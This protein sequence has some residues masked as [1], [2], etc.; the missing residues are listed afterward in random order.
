MFHSAL[1]VGIAIWRSVC[2]PTDEWG[3]AVPSGPG[4]DRFCIYQENIGQG[5]TSV[6]SDMQSLQRKVQAIVI[7]DCGEVVSRS[8]FR[9][10][11]R[12]ASLAPDFSVHS[13]GVTFLPPSRT[14]IYANIQSFSARQTSSY[15][16]MPDRSI[17]TSSLSS[18]PAVGTM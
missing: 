11:D 9:L 7:Q 15:A 5:V 1:F 8:T 13:G 18:K 14:K 16:A 10:R 3:S 17:K 2:G 6:Q 4:C 12:Q